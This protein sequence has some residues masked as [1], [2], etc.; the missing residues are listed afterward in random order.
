M[1]EK[2]GTGGFTLLE[3]L[4]SMSILAIAA[5]IIYGSMSTGLDAVKRAEA[6]NE[7][8]QRVRII[9]EIVS[10]DL[11]HAYVPK[12]TQGFL[13]DL[14]DYEGELFLDDEGQEFD[15]SSGFTNAFEGVDDEEG[16]E[17]LDR[18]S[19][20]S[21]SKGTFESEMPVYVSYYVDRDPLTKET[22]LVMERIATI[23]PSESFRKELAYDVV[24]MNIRY[25]ESTPEGQVWVD[26]WGDKR[27]LPRAVEVT[28]IWDEQSSSMTPYTR[29]P[30]MV[31]ISST[32]VF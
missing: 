20:Y 12:Q 19:F 7:L 31:S 5:G 24:G 21:I 32:H 23:L 6:K 16:L 28:L 29:I 15:L 14:E 2:G 25:L 17:P 26:E 8:F 30:I 13:T 18:M 4:L 9:R 1:R 27:K 3:I 11:Q 10:E 22:G